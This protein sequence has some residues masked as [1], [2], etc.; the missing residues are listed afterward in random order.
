M[1]LTFAALV[2]FSRVLVCVWLS[3]LAIC[4]VKN[5]AGNVTQM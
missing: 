4:N 5:V 3:A 1:S 2:F